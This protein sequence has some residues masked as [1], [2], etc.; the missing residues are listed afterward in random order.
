MATIQK[1][2]SKSGDLSFLIRVSL[3]YD[4]QNKQIVKFVYF[5]NIIC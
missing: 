2:Q 5:M 3:G 4:N 1:R